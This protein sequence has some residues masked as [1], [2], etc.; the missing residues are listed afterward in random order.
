MYKVDTSTKRSSLLRE[1]H[2]KVQNVKRH[3]VFGPLLGR[4]MS[5]R[6]AGGRE[7]MSNALEPFSTEIKTKH[8][9]AHME[10]RLQTHTLCEPA[11]SKCMSRFHKSHC[12]NGNLP[13]KCCGLAGAP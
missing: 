3:C 9:A 13:E 5:F 1:A 12:V 6:M 11:R 8:A 4:K 10:P 7:Y 2:F